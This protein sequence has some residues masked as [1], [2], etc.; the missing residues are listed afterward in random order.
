[1]ISVRANPSTNRLPLPRDHGPETERGVNEMDEV[2]PPTS[3]TLP[4][5]TRTAAS[6]VEVVRV[7]TNVS[8]GK[9]HHKYPCRQPELDIS[10]HRQPKWDR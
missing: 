5:L 2:G 4:G 3:L 8:I 6:V 1:M 9:V 10:I 7:S